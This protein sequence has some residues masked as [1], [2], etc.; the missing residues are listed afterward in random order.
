MKNVMFLSLRKRN[1]TQ[2]LMCVCALS[3]SDNLSHSVSQGVESY[4]NVCSGARCLYERPV[5]TT[6]AKKHAQDLF[7]CIG[8]FATKTKKE[9]LTWKNIKSDNGEQ[10][11]TAKCK[12]NLDSR[13]GCEETF[14]KEGR[15]VKRKEKGKKGRHPSPPPPK[16]KENAISEGVDEGKESDTWTLGRNAEL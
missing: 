10:N 5:L 1:K 15:T 16:K 12:S 9:K 4:L 3:L 7:I 13:R 14:C 2:L 6:P 8:C 11:E